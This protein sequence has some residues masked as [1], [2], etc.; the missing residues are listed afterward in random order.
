MISNIMHT[1]HAMPKALVMLSCASSVLTLALMKVAY[2]VGRRLAF[3]VVPSKIPLSII[4]NNQLLPD[5]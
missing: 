1:M 5:R 4:G 2:R 3:L